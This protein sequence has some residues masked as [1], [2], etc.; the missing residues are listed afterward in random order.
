M[1]LRQQN[2][3][4]ARTRMIDAARDLIAE[5]GVEQATT[6]EI[7]RRAGVSYQTLYN[8]YPTKALIIGELMESEFDAL[9]Q[10]LQN[11]IKRYDGDLLATI[12]ALV[13][14]NLEMANGEH[15]ALLRELTKVIFATG[16]DD[17]QISQKLNVAHEQFHALLSMAIGTGEL[18]GDV[19]VHLMAHT[20]F[21]LLDYAMLMAIL[22]ELDP[23]VT[24]VNIDQQIALLL[25]PYLNG[26]QITA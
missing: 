21:N 5:V 4:L 15:R 22:S 9:T 26:G 23:E 6:R 11:I 25:S 2:K 7:A 12:S 14:V 19:D 8:Y 18:R 13:A 3:R 10:V 24:R 20:L 17:P 16:L 1:S